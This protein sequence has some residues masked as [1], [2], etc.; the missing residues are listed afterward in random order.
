M[1]GIIVATT[2]VL[3]KKPLSNA[4]GA[5]ILV[6]ADRTV[7]G[8]PRKRFTSRSI[9]PDPCSPAATT[10]IAA[11]VI[12]PLLLNPDNASVAVRMPVTLS[13]LS[14]TIITRWGPIRVVANIS[15][16]PSV[17]ANDKMPCQSIN[18]T[19]PAQRAARVEALLIFT[20]NKK[21][22]AGTFKI[23][24]V[25]RSLCTLYFRAGR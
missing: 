22:S 3:F 6:K 4:T 15:K 21:L 19:S 10:N 24:R 23:Y 18:F 13:M 17:N 8:R 7:L 12:T 11:T 16:A 25:F 2:G 14:T 20:K 9:P 5:N 1:A